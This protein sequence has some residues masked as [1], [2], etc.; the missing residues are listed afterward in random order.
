[1]DTFDTHGFIILLFCLVDECTGELEQHG[2][3]KLHPSEIV[4]LALLKR[5][6]GKAYR[7]FLVWLRTTG[8]FPN[9]PHFSTLCRLFHRYQPVIEVF[10]KQSGSLPVDWAVIDSVHCEVIHPIRE[11]RSIDWVGKNKSKGRWVVGMR[12]ASVVSPKGDILEWAL[13]ASNIHDKHFAWLVESFEV[14]V[15]SD[16][17]FH[18]KDGDPENLKICQRGEQNERMVVESVFS[19][20]KRLLGMN[21]IQAKTRAGFELAISSIFALFNLLLEMNRRL[22]LF[23][24]RPSIAHFFCL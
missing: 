14:Q 19:L 11:G 18:S 23:A 15:L 24:E 4:T 22:G 9:L 1:M 5:M 6:T 16:K 2:N 13:D 17:G 21:Q 12:V 8:L 7:R 10:S 20:C 3:A